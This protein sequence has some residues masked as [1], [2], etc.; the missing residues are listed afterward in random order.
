ME[1][2][3]DITLT[4]IAQAATNVLTGADTIDDAS[5]VALPELAARVG[6]ARLTIARTG[7]D[8]PVLVVIRPHSEN[9]SRVATL[10]SPR[11]RQV[12]AILSRGETNRAIAAR[13][14]ISVATV[15][16]HVHRALA[17]TGASNRTE[18]A[19]LWHARRVSG[20]GS[21]PRAPR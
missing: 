13:L 9:D 16:D 18:L 4:Q 14:G 5:V 7:A 11:E 10:L 2:L 21:D 17:K 19:R 8:G 20:S 6:K 12:V 15:K 3:D 1:L